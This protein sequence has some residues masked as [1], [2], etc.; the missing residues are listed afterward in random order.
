MIRIA[1]DCLLHSNLP[2]S[3]WKEGVLPFPVSL[4]CRWKAVTY[5]R[6]LGDGT[7]SE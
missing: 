4:S 1:D 7:F 5:L 3:M 6:H 2:L